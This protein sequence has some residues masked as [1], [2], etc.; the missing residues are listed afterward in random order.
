MRDILCCHPELQALQEF[1]L[2][3][4]LVTENFACPNRKPEMAPRSFSSSD[5]VIQTLYD[6]KNIMFWTGPVG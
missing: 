5:S 1:L 6:K 2:T 3:N 4:C